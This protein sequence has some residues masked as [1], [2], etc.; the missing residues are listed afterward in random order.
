[1]EKVQRDRHD[2]VF[3]DAQ[4]G[5]RLMWCM[6]CAWMCKKAHRHVLHDLCLDVQTSSCA[7]QMMCCM[8]R[9]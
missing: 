4:A 1:M 9:V 8:M 5:H 3:L 7:A 2:D 6:M